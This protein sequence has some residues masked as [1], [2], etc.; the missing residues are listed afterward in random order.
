MWCRY[1][2]DV[3]KVMELNLTSKTKNSDHE[4]F[5]I[6]EITVTIEENLDCQLFDKCQIIFSVFL[7]FLIICNI[8]I[9]CL[10]R[11]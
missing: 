7:L 3:K 9:I 5:Q 2:F 8:I 6:T 4:L 11:N 10:L 1:N